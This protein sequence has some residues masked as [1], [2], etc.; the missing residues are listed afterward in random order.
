MNDSEKLSANNEEEP[1]NEIL[2]TIQEALSSARLLNET[3]EAS[4]TSVNNHPYEQIKQ[5]YL[6]LD[7]VPLTLDCIPAPQTFCPMS[8][9]DQ[10]SA[11]SCEFNN[12]MSTQF[13]AASSEQDLSECSVFAVLSA[14]ENGNEFIID[15]PRVGNYLQFLEMVKAIPMHAVEQNSEE[16]ARKLLTHYISIFK[17]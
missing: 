13:T 16:I 3:M 10:L 8:C 6:G 9:R 15:Q 5:Q 2:K 11:I 17:K 1:V 4:L 14:T 12:T 7:F